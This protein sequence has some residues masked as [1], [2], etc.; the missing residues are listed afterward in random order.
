MCPAARAEERQ[1]DQL[2]FDEIL[3]KMVKP[4]RKQAGRD[5]AVIRT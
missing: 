3:G 4:E 5:L 2:T 1:R